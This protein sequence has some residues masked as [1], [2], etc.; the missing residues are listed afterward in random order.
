MWYRRGI[1]S[2]LDK[3]CGRE[4]EVH[5]GNV[6]RVD[7]WSVG[8]EAGGRSVMQGHEASP[9]RQ[10]H[11]KHGYTVYCRFQPSIHEYMFM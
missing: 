10:R 3:A 11:V 6:D 9:E 1:E 7:A 5:M 4:I 2:R 8:R